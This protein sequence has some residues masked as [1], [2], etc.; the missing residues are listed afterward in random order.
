MHFNGIDEGLF[1]IKGIIFVDLS[2]EEIKQSGLARWNTD[3]S[4][5]PLQ[6]SIPEC[7]VQRR[8]KTA[9]GLMSTPKRDRARS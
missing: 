5:D 1:K 4:V 9:K 8:N 7:G 6:E 3:E 2:N